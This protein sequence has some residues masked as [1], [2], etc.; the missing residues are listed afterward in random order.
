MP[1][2]A[3]IK[4]VVNREGL[5]QDEMAG[6]MNT[7]MT[8]RATPAQIGALLVG[9]RIKGETV[10]EI[11]GAVATM[12]EK[13][14]RV[15]HNFDTV[16][17]TCGTGGDGA[18]TFN[19]STAVAFVCAGAGVKVGKHGNRA[20]S[21]RAGSADVLEALGV[22]IDLSLEQVTHCL[23]DVGLAFLFAQSHH[24]AMKFV[25]GP[26][27]ELGVRTMMNMVGPLTNPAGATHQLVGV[28]DQSLLH[29]VAS[30]LGHLG[31][32][33]AVV[34]HGENGMDE[35][36][37]CG[38]TFIA[39]CK[40]GLISTH[41]THPDDF[42]LAPIDIADIAGGDAHENAQIIRAVLAG[43]PG[44]C[45]STV[46]INAAHAL[47]AADAVNDP[48]DGFALATEAI[49]SGKAEAVLERLISFTLGH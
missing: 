44:P 8:G 33:H 4:K 34:V 26:R 21:S 16:L 37:P 48:L 19:I 9:L 47:F 31:A 35:V 49:D 23:T 39:R 29:T 32:V 2:K 3:A 1:L 42:G 40:E 13:V 5:T 43:D 38:T 45:R 25:A 41:L 15:E 46:L 14:A 10:E 27:K 7:I 18:G 11:S 17:D 28:Y 36:S 30:V 24:P 6:A 12:R 22:R 20:V